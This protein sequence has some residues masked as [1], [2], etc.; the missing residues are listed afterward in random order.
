MENVTVKK[1]ALLETLRVNRAEHIELYDKAMVEYRKRAVEELD[2]RL[3]EARDGG[4]ISL[5]ISLPVPE[6]HL[7]DYDRAIA[8]VEWSIA[9]EIELSEYDF[10]SYVLN[11]WS[12]LKSWTQNS[13]G[14]TQAAR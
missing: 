9:D 10:A 3:K 1:D 5:V 8:M 2:R 13:L 11:Q 14:Y 6:R 4:A 7:D 12:W